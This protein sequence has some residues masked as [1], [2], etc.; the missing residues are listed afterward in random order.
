MAN[1]VRN[2]GQFVPGVSP[3]PT[4]AHAYAATG[5]LREEIRR[6]NRTGQDAH[7]IVSWLWEIAGGDYVESPDGEKIYEGK[8]TDRLRAIEM[9][10]SY[11]YGKPLEA[12]DAV[13]PSSTAAKYDLARLSDNERTTLALT[14]A[15]MASSK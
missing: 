13:A 7:Q 12:P 9:L 15:K 3:N 6:R 8:T 11:G 5:E 1:L 2:K 10:L 14:L 4:G